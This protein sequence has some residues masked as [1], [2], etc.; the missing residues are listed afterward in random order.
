MIQQD[1]APA[2]LD[3]QIL[4]DQR[5]VAGIDVFAQLTVGQPECC[6]PDA[7]NIF[8]GKRG[9]GNALPI[10]KCA[11]VA[12]Q[13]DNLVLSVTGFAQ[14]CM[15]PGDTEVGKDE[16]IVRRPANPEAV[17]GQR[18]HRGG[19]P[20]HTQPVVVLL[21]SPA[22]AAAIVRRARAAAGSAAAAAVVR[23]ARAGGGAGGAAGGG[24]GGAAAVNVLA[25]LAG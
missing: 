21:N 7:D 18:Q 8:L 1:L 24:A 11:I 10:D 22:A 2:D 14:F 13:V 3:D 12:V 19:A 23:R 20:V 4:R 16:V 15:M 6:G 5:H 17:H 9:G 25:A